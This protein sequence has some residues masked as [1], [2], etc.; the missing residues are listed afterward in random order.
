MIAGTVAYLALKS[1]EPG[2][3]PRLRRVSL[4]ATLYAAIK[5]Q[6][7]FG[8]ADDASQQLRIVSVGIIRPPTAVGALT[9]LLQRLLQ[10]DPATRPDATT[11]RDL[12]E[13][14]ATHINAPPQART[15]WRVAGR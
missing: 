8:R 11:A 12:L 5:G 10:L 13:E 15:R 3:L 9:P 7:P 6:P 2:N 4:G 1:Q 14:F